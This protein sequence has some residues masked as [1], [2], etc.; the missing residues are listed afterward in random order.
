[1][2]I[3]LVLF[4]ASC[5][6]AQD[7]EGWTFFCGNFT[8]GQFEVQRL[9]S[10]NSGSLPLLFCKADLRAFPPSQSQLKLTLHIF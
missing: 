2:G 8:I 7:F 9:N 6:F 1:M 3:L 5:I 4:I 10:K